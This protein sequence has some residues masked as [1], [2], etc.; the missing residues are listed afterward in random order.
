M[1][2]TLKTGFARIL[3]INNKLL[4]INQVILIFITYILLRYRYKTKEDVL[5]LDKRTVYQLIK[6]NTLESL[7]NNDITEHLPK[8][9]ELIK[10]NYNNQSQKKDDYYNI[11]KNKIVEVIRKYGIGTCGP[12]GFYGTC[13]LHLE[14]ENVITSYYINKKESIKQEE[15]ES[16]F[17]SNGA[18]GIISTILTFVKS[19]HNVFIDQN[20]HP[21][22]KR[23]LKI[24]KATIYEKENLIINVAEYKKLKF[25][26]I[27]VDGDL[28]DFKNL[29]MYKEK[30]F[31]IIYCSSI[32]RKMTVPDYIDVFFSL[33][34]YNGGFA[35]CTKSA[36]EYMKLTAASYVFSASLPAFLAECN[37][38]AI[39]SVFKGNSEI[40]EISDSLKNLLISQNLKIL[41]DSHYLVIKAEK[42]NGFIQNLL[43]KYFIENYD[44][45]NFKI[46]KIRNKNQLKD[47]LI[48]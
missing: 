15:K 25:K 31:R 48:K 22:V 27:V 10:I 17:L 14:L 38:Q 36:I 20:S 6:K 7:I 41:R 35:I 9:N 34:P 4:L 1:I 12:R 23:A 21:L 30:G 42:N 18:T 47:I 46:L 37:I 5:N 32:I 29:K 26:F 24:S 44:V 19:K 8:N 3:Q 43:K 39:N 28:K 40:S 11:D 13:I 33:L 16:L 2:T 45:E